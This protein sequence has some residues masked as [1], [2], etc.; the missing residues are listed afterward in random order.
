M[1]I[2]SFNKYYIKKYRLQFLLNIFFLV[3]CKILEF[4]IP[5]VQSEMINELSLNINSFYLNLAVLILMLIM[6]I[7]FMFLGKVTSTKFS[8]SISYDLRERLNY[9]LYEISSEDSKK[10]QLSQIT[11]LLN[12]EIYAVD[13]FPLNIFDFVLNIIMIISI[14][15]TMLK[16]NTV[17]SLIV[18]L[19]IVVYLILT[20]LISR[21]IKDL[22]HSVLDNNQEVINEIEESYNNNL[23]IKFFNAKNYSQKRFCRKN[24]DYR[25]NSM[26]L[27]YLYS[28]NSLV[29]FSTITVGLIFI[30]S[31]GG[32]A[33]L[34]NKMTV[35]DIWMITSYQSMLL[36]PVRFITDFNNK[37]SMATVSLERLNE[38]YNMKPEN[39]G[40][41]SMIKEISKIELS[42]VSFNYGDISLLNDINLTLNRGK[43][44]LIVGKSGT[45]KTT[46]IKLLLGEL[47][48][49]EG[50]V[51]YND[52]NLDSLKKETYRN[53]IAYIS[54][55]TGFFEDSIINNIDVNKAFSEG[56]VTEMFKELDILDEI[57]KLGGYL[58]K[59]EKMGSNLSTGQKV[60]LDFARNLLKGYSVI[61]IDEAIASLDKK[62]KDIVYNILEKRKEDCIIIIISHDTN[63]LQLADEII[64]L[65]N[66]NSSVS[67]K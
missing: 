45:G 8:E 66:I 5:R 7:I 29:A 60:R 6:N 53:K 25:D 51:T 63:E 27:G 34:N 15:Y 32:I 54:N 13:D 64:N 46:L 39:D 19:I 44:Y 61:I 2:K 21:R 40:S 4:F 33:V 55:N 59:I 17:I 22:S 26:R 65:N 52:L 57:T 58:Y 41:I 35:G 28:L 23:L 24:I 31:I 43:I 42:N 67:S 56:T 18:F 62:R 11:S 47:N 48:P 12:K 30:W 37:Y 9:K 20:N 16:T 36:A 1:N 38:I 10:L 50:I 49:C 3:S 14:S